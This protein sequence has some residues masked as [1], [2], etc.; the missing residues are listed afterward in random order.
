MSH[1]TGFTVLDFIGVLLV[2]IV[3]IVFVGALLS[4]C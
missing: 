3:A 4:A 1:H 2:W